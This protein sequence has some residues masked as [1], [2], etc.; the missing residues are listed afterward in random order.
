MVY[1]DGIVVD[2]MS[3]GFEGGVEE[4]DLGGCFII[5]RD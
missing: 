2:F 4:L 1:D 3:F 5:V